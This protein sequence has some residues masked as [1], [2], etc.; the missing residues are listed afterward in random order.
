MPNNTSDR[1][2]GMSRNRPNNA[3]N[4]NTGI[5]INAVVGGM[6][7]H[8]VI[9]DDILLRFTILTPYPDSTHPNT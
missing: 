3:F 9:N 1:I 7:A 6:D 8:G 4:T 5:D 2:E